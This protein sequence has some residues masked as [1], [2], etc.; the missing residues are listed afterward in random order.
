NGTF[1]AAFGAGL[2]IVMW[3]YLGW[4]SLST[5]AAEVERPKRNFPLAFAIALPLIVLCYFLPT[6]I[7]ISA[8]PDVSRWKDGSWPAIARVIGGK[9]L[10]I[11]VALG[12]VISAAGL[13][14]ATLL[15]SSRIPFV[16]ARDK[17]LPAFV[18]KLHPRFG[19]P[20]VAILISAVIY[21]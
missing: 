12:G 8:V 2:Y 6:L 4:D 20:W 21:T 13:F 7:G 1:G 18:T 15:A 5:I 9:W 11:A 16:L 3:N 19:T 14:M 10:G 17:M